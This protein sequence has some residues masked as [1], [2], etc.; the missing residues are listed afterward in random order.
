VKSVDENRKS[1]GFARELDT[2]RQQN[3]LPSTTE[4]SKFQKENFMMEIL[5]GIFPFS[6]HTS[7]SDI[8][9]IETSLITFDWKLNTLLGPSNCILSSCG[10]HIHNRNQTPHFVSIL[11]LHHLC[12]DELLLLRN[13]S[14]SAGRY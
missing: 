9:E 7:S 5:S 3:P 12:C 8:K 14:S 10:A 2:C 13:K 4:S 11:C 6:Q 1:R